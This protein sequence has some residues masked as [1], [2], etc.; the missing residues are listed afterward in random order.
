LITHGLTASTVKAILT[1][2]AGERLSRKDV[3]WKRVAL[4]DRLLFD[5]FQ[6]YYRRM[7]PDFATFFI[8][9]T[10]HLQHAY[11]RQMDPDGFPLKPPAEEVDTYGNA[12]LFGYQSMDKLLYQFSRIVDDQTIVIL[13]SA[14]SQQP[15]VKRDSR[16]G[17]H[18]YRL[19]DVNRFA[20][21]LGIRPERIEPVMTHQY[22]FRFAGAGEARAAA[23]VLTAIRLGG[24]QVISV[25]ISDDNS[26]YVGC[27]IY[28]KQLGQTQLVG[29]PENNG[30]LR[31]FDLFY[32]IDAVKSGRH[33]P[34]GL[35]WIRNGKHAVNREPVSILDIAPTIYDLMGVQ[36]Q[37]SVHEFCYG[38]SLVSRFSSSP[39]AEKRVA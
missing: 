26:I 15:F 4:Q 35:L 22:M 34:D 25:D 31:F 21:L 6:H 33:H 17:Q 37:S 13:C 23:S 2:L 39:E 30:E 27:Q 29:I 3:R 5:V 20:E 38:T 32:A 1:Q 18:F 16:G 14:L 12:V 8:N 28:E 11:W 36:A 19:R 10:A 24:D 9:S 7:R